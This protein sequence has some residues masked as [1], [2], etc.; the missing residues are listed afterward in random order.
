[1]RITCPNCGVRYK[2]SERAVGKRVPCKKCGEVIAISAPEMPDPPPRPQAQQTE[3]CPECGE[4][5]SSGAVIC[6]QCGF[7]RAEG[8]RVSTEIEKGETAAVSADGGPRCFF[9]AGTN[10]DGAVSATFEQLRETFSEEGIE[11][12]V[13]RIGA[14]QTPHTD[15]DDICV[16][17]S[18]SEHS[19]GSR[20]VRYFLTPLSLFFGIGACKLAVD[21]TYVSPEGD[22]KD[23]C[24]K[25]RQ[26]IGMFG[27]NSEKMMETN[28]KSVAR[29]FSHKIARLITGR[30]VLNSTAY[31]CALASL[32]MGLIA[33]VIPYLCFVLWIPAVACGAIATV[34]VYRRDLPKRKW[35]SL[36]GLVISI[37]SPALTI[38]LIAAG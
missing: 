29:K 9:T 6:V 34:T 3:V 4:P 15:G 11:L 30:W 1:M 24:I 10:T 35:M 7:N 33:L 38:W 5:M 27:G 8:R 20:F 37:I 36:A 28:V 19:Y 17:G 26:G 25:A 12:F 2:V 32:I 31:G 13:E 21:G 14:A 16:R 18:V 22:R 23:F